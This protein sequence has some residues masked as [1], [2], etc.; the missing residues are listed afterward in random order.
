MLVTPAQ[1]PMPKPSFLSHIGVVS[2]YSVRFSVVGIEWNSHRQIT[3]RGKCKLGWNS[4]L[5]DSD[6]ASGCRGGKRA[7]LRRVWLNLVGRLNLWV[8]RLKRWCFTNNQVTPKRATWKLEVHW[9]KNKGEGLHF[10]Q[11]LIKIDLPPC[12]IG[13]RL[14]TLWLK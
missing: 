8:P 7:E 3:C 12:L 6:I 5:P 10:L 4:H 9:L 14:K 2:F 11:I 13:S 1:S